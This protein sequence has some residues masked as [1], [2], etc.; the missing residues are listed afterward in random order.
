M[1]PCPMGFHRSTACATKTLW[2]V[3][4][5]RNFYIRYH[6]PLGWRGR[7]CRA[8]RGKRLIEVY[9]TSVS[10]YW[11]ENFC[12]F[13]E[14]CNFGMA[15]DDSVRKVVQEELK[16]MIPEVF[17]NLYELLFKLLKQDTIS[18]QIHAY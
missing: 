15:M 6:S 17:N 7:R 5:H 13:R 3:H 4:W 12:K 18:L 9:L 2:F 8:L 14:W 11:A 10:I 1:P 16:Y